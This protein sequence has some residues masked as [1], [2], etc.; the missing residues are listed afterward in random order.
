LVFTAWASAT[1]GREGAPP[2]P[3]IFIDDTD[4]IEEG[5]LVLFFGLVFPVTPLSLEIFLPSL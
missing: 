5:L 3:W 1:R 4:K 2:H